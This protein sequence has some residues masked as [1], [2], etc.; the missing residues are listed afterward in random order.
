MVRVLETGLPRPRERLET[1]QTPRYLELRHELL[2]M[3]LGQAA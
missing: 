3:L 1:P 2:A